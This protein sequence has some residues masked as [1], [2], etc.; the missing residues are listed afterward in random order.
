MSLKILYK[1]I[2]GTDS[3]QRRA[4]Y[5]LA[6]WLANKV[7]DCWFPEDRKTW[8]QDEAFFRDYRRLEPRDLRSA[9]RKFAVRELVRSIPD[10]PG[11]TAECGTYRGA[12]S[13]FI[14]LARGKGKHHIFD[15]FE[16]LS[17]PGP[18][19]RP[20]DP[21][22]FL[23]KPGDFSVSE[24]VARQN[25]QEFPYV[26]YHRGWIPERFEDV[27]DR[28]FCFV[29]IDVDLYQPTLESLLFFYPRMERGGIIVCDD[30]GF[31][32][33]PG[34]RKACDEFFEDKPEP[35]IHLPTGQG[36]IFVLGQG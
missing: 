34:A 9:E 25:L 19:D 15:S 29:H 12:T 17:R 6:E 1:I 16:G 8:L 7:C 4:R 14:C 13:Y 36:V 10:V 21:Y 24:D 35:I 20:D 31:S 32:T 33:C 22:A 2:F 11:D 23:W 30:Y 18:Q 5:G 3:E 27:R 26:A 28:R